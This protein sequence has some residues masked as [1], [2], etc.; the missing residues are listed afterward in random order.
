VKPFDLEELAAR[1]RAVT[2]RGQGAAAAVLR[3]NGS[4]WI[5][6]STARGSGANRSS[7]ARRISLL[8]ELMLNAGRVLSREQLEQRFVCLG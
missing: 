6:P 5:P 8:H 3:V 2:R 7:S 4:S 1:L